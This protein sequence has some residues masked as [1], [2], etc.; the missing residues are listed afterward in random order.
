MWSPKLLRTLGVV[1]VI[2]AVTACGKKDDEPKDKQ[3]PKTK[4]A[5]VDAAAKPMPKQPVKLSGAQVVALVDGLAGVMS[6]LD[7]A[8]LGGF[9]TPGASYVVKGTGKSV[10]GAGKIAGYYRD[11][12]AGFP[13]M[14]I[15]QVLLLVNDQR[16][17]LVYRAR[18]TNSKPM[19]GI[20][21]SNKKVSFRVYEHLDFAEGR[22]DRVLAYGD[23]LNFL[24]QL[25]VYKGRHR[26]Y[27]GKDSPDRVAAVAKGD[28]TERE[29]LATLTKLKDYF[30]AKDVAALA[31]LYAKDAVVI[32]PLLSVEDIKG[33]KAIAA[34]MARLRKAFGDANISELKAWAAGDYV[35]ATYRLTGS[36][37]GRYQRLGLNKTGK[38]MGLDAA[39]VL[40]LDKGKITRQWVFADAAVLAHQLGALKLK[41]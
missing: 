3:P 1:A 11:F 21:P 17:A 32:D 34:A 2:A 26:K 16:A 33:S 22:I 5:V 20:K 24:G 39:V 4:P 40:K 13:D 35:T 23:N 38:R 14:K 25:G 37:N 29:N 41:L 9:Y 36:H 19:M 31:K 27:D 18:G 15:D 7:P 30:N 6:P 8:K 12:L 10:S 28:D